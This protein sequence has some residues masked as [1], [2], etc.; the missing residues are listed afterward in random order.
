MLITAAALQTW[1]VPESECHAELS[2]IHHRSSG[3]KLAY[4]ELVSA[5]AKLPVPDEKSVKLKDPATYTLMGKRISGVDN[6]QIVTGKP[7]FG[8]DVKLPGMLYAVYEKCP[9]FGGKPMNANLQR[10]KSLRGVRDA[11]IIEGTSNVN[12]LMPGVA[13][14]ADSTWAAMSARQQLRVTWDEGKTA[15][16]NWSDFA[17]KAEEIANQPGAQTTRNDGNVDAAFAAN[18]VKMM[19]KPWCP[20]ARRGP[21]R[22]PA[23]DAAPARP[24]AGAPPEA[25]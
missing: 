8:M 3:R 20:S 10:I 12:G 23:R 9:V 6:P 4:G 14:V 13:I 22:C 7:L 21:A 1:K 11:F 5:A 18:G 2:A 17:A 24:S 16:E 19:T 25:R 15:S